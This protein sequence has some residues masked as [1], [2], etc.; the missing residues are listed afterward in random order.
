MK[1]SRHKRKRVFFLFFA[2]IGLPSLFL[3][4]LAFRGIQNDRALVEKSRLDEH[5]RIA[6]LIIREVDENISKAEQTLLDTISN[7][8]G[9]AQSA[10]IPSLESFK[11]RHS[12]V[13]EVFLLED[14]K[15]IHYPSAKLLF[16]PDGGIN[17]ISA[18]D[19]SPSL[20][21]MIEVGEQLEF[22][23]K[24]YRKALAAYQQAFD[25]AS[26][27][28]MKGKLLNA[29]ARVQKKS[30]LFQDALRSYEIVARDYSGV[31]VG[32]GVPLGLA[33]RFEL[34]SLFIALQDSSS[35][36]E[37]FVELYKSL[38]KA[39]WPLE[40]AQYEFFAQ[41]VK[42]SIDEVFS[43]APL[44]SRLQ[45]YK[46]VFQ[47]LTEEEKKQRK[48]TERLLSFQENSAELEARIA[49]GLSESGSVKRLS[50]DI[51]KHYYLVSLLGSA[52]ADG[53]WAKE[54]WGLLFNPDFLR[55]NVLLPGLR[56]QVLSKETAWAIK[57]SDGRPILM[58]EDAPSGAVTVRADFEGNFPNWTLEFAQQNPRL[59]ETFLT[60][61]RG[62]YFYVF[63]L[64]AGIL[65]FGLILTVRTVNRE[66][67]LARMKS[68]FVSTISHEFKSPLTS[69]RQLA[70]MLQTGRVPSEERRQEY[71]DVLLEQ[72]ERLT[73][74]TDNVLN[75]ARIEEGRKEYQFET[76]DIAALVR[77]IV[78]TVQD[79]V[80][81]EGFFIEVKLEEPLP[82][83]MADRAAI[84]QALTNLMD[85][86]IK[87][88]DKEK[89]VK[90]SSFVEGQ[91]LVIEVKDFGVG[92]KKEEIDRV[93]ERFYRG[94]DELTRTVKGS[95]LGLTLVKEIIEAHRGHVRVE[96]EPGRGSTF[97]IRLPLKGIEDE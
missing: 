85:N 18:R 20:A 67:E 39:E 36:L 25:R 81:H 29:M 45:S 21:G 8:R 72:S 57:G 24:E 37:I 41:N 78:T 27:P 69:I 59:V 34:G 82:P 52:S 30:E 74:L 48:R 49:A 73:L 9:D 38:I 76:V 89:K 4:Y 90:V 54:T 79:R 3:A 66:L 92:I 15:R 19:R 84:T 94:G 46:N 13:E 71:Y 87:Y 11:Q 68:D 58:S 10:L 1:V 62:L 22:Q 14:L 70:E 88:S 33:A 77:E 55:D 6:G 91:N 50:L 12:L 95:G 86:A 5:R 44:D 96:S 17:L 7:R 75:L 42:N 83:V 51:G 31:R 32:D 65:G 23:Q 2:G 64:I 63:L 40:K 61:R 56:R 60:S 43:R 26:D 28:Q 80:R 16:L 97:S 93:F 35:S 53:D 47:T